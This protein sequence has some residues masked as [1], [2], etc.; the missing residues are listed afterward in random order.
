[1]VAAAIAGAAVVG[2]AASSVASSNAAGAQKDAAQ[3]A[4]NTQM[5]MFNQIQANEAP[6]V[7]VGQQA[8]GALAQF[9]G[10]P[11][12]A[13]P[14]ANAPTYM[15]GPNGRMIQVPQA[16]MGGTSAASTPDYNKIL[17]NLPGYQFQLQQG[18]QAVQRNLAANGLLNSGAAQKAL[19]QYGQGVA[20]S[21][22]GQ[23]AG[24]LAT[25]SQLGEAGAAGV[26]SAGINAANQISGNQIYAGN[27]AAAGI[28]NTGNAINTGLGGLVSSYGYASQPNYGPS[29]AGYPSYTPGAVDTQT[30]PSLY[31][32]AGGGGYIYNTGLP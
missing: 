12:S 31:A 27:A 25:L 26:A 7:N 29:A 6:W 23:Y 9:Y 5:G 17:S 13:A 32:P 14:A 3:T 19:T 21:Y 4:S 20:Q 8:S 30:D 18:T 1:M 15:P 11:G 28:A 24:G 10:L 16:Q 2:A 22:A